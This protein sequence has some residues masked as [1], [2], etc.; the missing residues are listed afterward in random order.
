MIPFLE[1]SSVPFL[2]GV[3]V[4]LLIPHVLY[5]SSLRNQYL[6]QYGTAPIPFHFPSVL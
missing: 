3:S 5:L 2:C 1:N 6:I 4:D